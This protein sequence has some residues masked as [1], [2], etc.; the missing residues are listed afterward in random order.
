MFDAIPE[1]KK[2]VVVEARREEEFSPVKNPSGEDSADSARRDMSNLFRDWLAAAGFEIEG[3]DD[4]PIEISPEF[5]L[6]RDELARRMKK[7]RTLGGGRLRI[8]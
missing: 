4:R 5:A 7:E 2:S 8:G 1:A 3:D 6:D